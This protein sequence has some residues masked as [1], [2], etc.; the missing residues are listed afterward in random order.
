MKTTRT[1]REAKDGRLIADYRYVC[2]ARKPQSVHCDR[3]D[4]EAEYARMR[5]EIDLDGNDWSH[6]PE[7]GKVYMVGY[8]TDTTENGSDMMVW[9]EDNGEGFPG[10]SDP[11]IKCYHGWR[12]TYNDT[13]FYACGLRR[14]LAIRET[15]KR[16]RRTVIVFGRDLAKDKE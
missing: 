9:R 1:V 3:I 4:E 8:S 12:G 2:E 15:G 11:S 6:R 14:C 16:S 10:N 13:A 7:I 5:Q